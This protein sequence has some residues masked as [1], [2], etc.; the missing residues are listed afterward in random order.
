MKGQGCGAEPDA[1]TMNERTIQLGD[2]I[3]TIEDIQVVLN[4]EIVCK[5]RLSHRGAPDGT[6]AE[7]YGEVAGGELSILCRTP[8]TPR[9]FEIL[10]RFL[11]MYETNIIRFF[12]DATRGM[13]PFMFKVPMS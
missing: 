5:F 10:A 9:R 3:L 8:L 2:I 1:R 11:Y 12:R 7:L 4:D 6:L 13:T